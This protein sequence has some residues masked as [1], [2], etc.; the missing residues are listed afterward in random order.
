MAP[1]C[2]SELAPNPPERSEQV[3]KA[4]RRVLAQCGE[5]IKRLGDGGSFFVGDRG[6]GPAN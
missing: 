6:V 5:A 4:A 3:K 1:V 2:L